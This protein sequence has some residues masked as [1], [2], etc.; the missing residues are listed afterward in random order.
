[1][2]CKESLAS[3]DATRKSVRLVN[4]Q[5]FILVS[6]LTLAALAIRLLSL[7][8]YHFIGVD[9]GVDGVGYAISGRNLLSGLGYSYQGSPQLANPPFYS[10]LI[11][12]LW[13]PTQ[14]LEFSGQIVSVISGSLLVIPLFYLTKKMYTRQAGILCAIFV[15]VC[16]PL[17]FGS[18]EVRVASLYTLLLWAAVAI[19]WKALTS[20]SLF[21]SA[22]TGLMLALCYLTRAEAIM[23]IPIFLLL[24]LLSF[25]LKVGVS[26]SIAKSIVSKSVLLIAGFALV[27]SPFW[28]FLYG[29]TGKWTLST[30]G[31]Y[32]FIGYYGGNWEKDNFELAA[33]PEAAQS[34][35]LD[36]GGLLNFVV[37]N[38]HQIL[39]RWGHN[40]VSIWSG[41][42]KQTQVLGIS[43]WALRGG[44][45]FLVLFV[46]FAF[47]RFIWTRH[48]AAKHIY[49][50]L[51]VS[52]SLIYFF[53]AIDWRYFYP[54]FPFLL[55]GLARMTTII[56][57][58]AKQNVTCGDRAFAK[59]VVYFP[60]G[61][62]LLGMSSYSGVLIG[63]K[64]N[65]APY[66]YKIMG[67]WMK[68]N[69]NDI[70]N[71]IVM[72]R[73]LGVPFYGRAKHEPLYY[74]EYLGLIEYAKSKKV[75]YLV[76][77]QWTIPK[78]RP[79]FAFLLK[80][81]KKHPGLQLV[82]KVR[83]KDRKTVLYQ[84]E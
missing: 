66:E 22:L 63:K 10:I 39:V 60:I 5:D 20:R 83:Y 16:P 57:D 79:Q 53:F 42:D 35:W 40:V 46:S 70:E 9:G 78:T 6:L 17:I 75:D 4:N 19:G 32:T 82:H 74:G 7:H 15:V 69:I 44:L 67:Q 52:S 54:Y 59:I 84:I 3:L 81:D 50:L 73:K 29:Q 72:S 30:R 58:W 56:Q 11:G 38:R 37:S 13:L 77:D 8:F 76:I 27:S 25:K 26:S 65:Y 51:I 68:E 2:C 28:V 71:K 34:E 64:M 23:L 31:P 1:M 62:L 43:P 47:I 14:N 49:L 21:W 36:Q 80:E 24:Y 61:V 18:T 41:R 33:N 45:I 12:I 55:I 48:I